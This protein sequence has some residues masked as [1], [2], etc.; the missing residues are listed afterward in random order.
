MYIEIELLVFLILIL[1]VVG[2]AVWH[3]LSLLRAIKNYKPEE[4]KSKYGEEKRRARLEG[5]EPDASKTVIDISKSEPV[6]KRKLLPSAIDS[7][8][9]EHIETTGNNSNNNKW[10][11]KF[12]SKFRKRK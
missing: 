7:T 10:F 3:N 12:I 9:G 6:R 11:D 8:T 1:L 2:W 4:D 5:R